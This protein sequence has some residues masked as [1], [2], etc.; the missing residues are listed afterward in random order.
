MRLQ[1]PSGAA[2]LAGAG[3][4]VT[5]AA[6]LAAP[7]APEDM[8]SF[9]LHVEVPD[10][11]LLASATAF[12]LAVLIVIAIAFSRDRRRHEAELRA[13]DQEPSNLPWW[14]QVVLR[15]LPLLPLLATLVIFA[16]GWQYVE[17]SLL[18]WSRL[19]LFPAAGSGA[20]D[21]EVPVVS[22]PWVGWLVGA[23]ALLVGLATLAVALLLLFAERVARWWERR[24][25]PWPAEPLT[26]A[27]EESLDDLASERDA[28]VA[29]IKCYRRFER[30]AARAQVPRAPWQTPDEFM[31]ATLKH[32]VLPHDAVDRL[33]RLF[34][35]ARFSRHALDSPE[36]ER[37]R[38]CLEE[39]RSA[40][41]REDEPVGVA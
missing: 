9:R 10:S 31:R 12:G 22:L 11:L 39:I 35:L 38:A 7:R 18:A 16:L 19:M 27:V 24:N 5:L 17:S 23:L 30:V 29:I 1:G 26:E 33:T 32:L 41:E 28:R 4:L 8:P 13:R 6:L 3:L 40:L 25:R 15:V 21:A 2:I 14:L 20:P 34:E 36:R 37:A